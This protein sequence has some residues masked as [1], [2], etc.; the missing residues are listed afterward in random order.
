MEK[1]RRIRAERE[2]AQAD[3]PYAPQMMKR[4]SSTSKK[5]ENEDSLGKYHRFMINQIRC[6]IIYH[7][8]RYPSEQRRTQV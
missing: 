5:L 3:H 1:A 8:I 4:L 7:S 6:D 2:S